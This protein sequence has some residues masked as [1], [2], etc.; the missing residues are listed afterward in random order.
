MSDQ[1]SEASK[2]LLKL[3]T[4]AS[5]G[6]VELSEG[7]EKH[8]GDPTETSIVLAAMKNGMPKQQLETE[9]PRKGNSF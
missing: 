9:C 3:G 4:L 8:I 6:V 7:K 5:D 1:L 2:N